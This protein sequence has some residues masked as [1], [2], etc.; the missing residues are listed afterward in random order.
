MND[1][2]RGLQG[3]TRRMMATVSELALYQALSIKY[4]AGRE[5]LQAQLAAARSNM[6]QGVAPTGSADQVGL[7]KAEVWLQRLAVVDT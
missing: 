2:Q 4:A 6:D 3:M 7:L 1:C 5:A